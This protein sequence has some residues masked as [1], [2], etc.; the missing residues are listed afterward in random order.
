MR[1]DYCPWVERLNLVERGNPLTSR[2][3]I[4]LDQIQMDIVVGS[5]SSND[6]PNRRDMQTGRGSRVGMAEF[7]GNQFV[8]SRSI[9]FALSSSAI[10]SFFGIWPGNAAF[11]MARDSGEAFRCITFTTFGV[12]TT[13]AFGNRSRI[14]PTPNQLI[15]RFRRSNRSIRTSVELSVLR[16]GR[17]RR[18]PFALAVARPLRTRERIIRVQIP[19]W[20][21]RHQTPVAVRHAG[22]YTLVQPVFTLTDR[23]NETKIERQAGQVLRRSGFPSLVLLR[24]AAALLA[25]RPRDNREPCFRAV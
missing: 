4:Q 9:S 8:S 10:T 21:R 13:L 17:P 25:Q 18:I 19:Q 20:L 16:G 7:Q 12:A 6:E 5:V 22:V 24:F 11:Q 1:G 2:L 3:R 15:F 14:V 23:E